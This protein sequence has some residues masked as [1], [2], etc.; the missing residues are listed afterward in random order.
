MVSFLTL[1]PPGDVDEKMWPIR[2]IQTGRKKREA[3]MAS[4]F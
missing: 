1:I 3:I 4:P 2:E